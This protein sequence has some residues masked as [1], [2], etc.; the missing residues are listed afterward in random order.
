M[1]ESQLKKYGMDPKIKSELDLSFAKIERTILNSISA[2]EDR[3]AIHQALKH[4]VVSGNALI[5]MAKDK[6]K[7]YPLNRYVVSRDGMGN[8]IEIVTKERINRKLIEQELP[9]SDKEPNP[10]MDQESQGT[11][12]EDVMSTP[13]SNVRTIDLFGIRKS[14]ERYFLSP[15]VLL[16]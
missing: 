15:V 1:D 10:A 13:M 12:S 14:T 11:R 2:S 3:V 6:L 4:L 5:F 8:V 9:T 16:H 7:V